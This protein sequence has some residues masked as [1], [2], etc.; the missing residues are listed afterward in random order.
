M[1][2]RD[3]TLWS[4]RQWMLTFFRDEESIGSGGVGKSSLTIRYMY[5]RGHFPEFSHHSYF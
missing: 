4:R 2:Y 3:S 5:L 1:D